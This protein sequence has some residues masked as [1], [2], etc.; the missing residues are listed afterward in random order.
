MKLSNIRFPS[1]TIMFGEKKQGRYDVHMDFYQGEGYDVDAID[2]NKHNTSGS[3]SRDGGSNFAFADGSWLKYGES[4]SPEVADQ[5]GIKTCNSAS[6]S[7]TDPLGVVWR[8]D[9]GLKKEKNH[10]L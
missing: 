3:E 6:F 1:E 5:T 10:F 4:L 8:R 2:Q 7:F 9:M